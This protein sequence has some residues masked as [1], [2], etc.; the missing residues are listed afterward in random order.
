MAAPAS[1]AVAEKADA[2]GFL[3]I[4]L[5]F[6]LNATTFAVW[7]PR[8]PDVKQLL[9][10]DAATLGFC[11]FAA[12]VGILIGFLFSPALIGRFGIRR[13]MAIAGAAF[14]IL[15]IIPGFAWSA[16]SL[17]AALFIVGL[18]V[19][20]IEIAMNA[21]ASEMERATGSRIM[22][23]CHGFW[24]LGSIIGATLG[25]CAS[26]LGVSFAAQQVVFMPIFAIAAYWIA[27]RTPR[28]AERGP[29]IA[30]PFALPSKEIAALC[31]LPLGV[32]AIEGAMMDWSAV[33]AREILS[34]A[35][36]LDATPFFVFAVAMTATRLFGDRLAARVGPAAVITG[37][38]LL[39][40][41]GVVALAGANGL[42]SALAAS[43]IAGVGV[44]NVYPLAISAAGAAD[45]EEERN[46]AAV[47]FVAFT[48]LLVAPP[49]I[50]ATA[51]IWGLRV[52]LGVIAPLAL[53]A[54]AVALST[55]QLRHQ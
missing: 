6:A 7:L 41:V 53:A 17:G 9:S 15:F 46:V 27:K 31:L 22:T 38:A 8:I 11:L 48:A 19:A 25:G 30:P 54:A 32:M 50:G 43:A 1:D 37:S 35:A 26:W 5:V 16:W 3:A 29:D 23:R 18:S 20:P 44:A 4:R 14:A 2:L 47:A 28:D 51:E 42:S 24:S 39:A 34:V 45:G 49:V 33:F 10:L 40:G 36:G 52:A 12:P 55:T 21:K 13:V